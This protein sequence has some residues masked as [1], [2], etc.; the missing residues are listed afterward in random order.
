MFRGLILDFGIIGSVLFMLATGLL[1]HMAF[2]SMLI[3]RRPVFTVAVFV[4]MIGYFYASFISS[5]VGVNR[6][7]YVTFVLLW[8]VLHIN[9][10]ITRTG[11]RWLATLERPV[12]GAA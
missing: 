1:L 2:H 12:G 8:I 5:L 9:R 3:N 4:L 7:Y 6:I 11:R 10:L